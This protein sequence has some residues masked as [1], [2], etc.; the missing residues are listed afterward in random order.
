MRP[1]RTVI[2]MRHGM[3]QPF[4]D[5]R[6]QHGQLTYRGR[7]LC[8]DMGKWIGSDL[9]EK[10]LVREEQASLKT[11]ADSAA[12]CIMSAEAFAEGFLGR[13]GPAEKHEG[14]PAGLFIPG[15]TG[16]SE[17]FRQEAEQQV[18]CHA[19]LSSLDELPYT[20]APELS[21]L[22]RLTG[23]MFSEGTAELVLEEGKGPVLT[24][25]LQTAAA[26]ADTILCH[27]LVRQPF[28]EHLSENDRNALA[29]IIDRYREILF[30]TEIIAKH[31][32]APF[33]QQLQN[34]LCSDAQENLL[35]SVHDTTIKAVLTVLGLS[36]AA[37][38]GNTAGEIP[39]GSC[40]CFEQF[41]DELN[42]PRTQIRRIC[43]TNDQIWE[44]APL[45]RMHPPLS[46]VLL[47]DLPGLPERLSG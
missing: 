26:A 45:N 6:F 9:Q 29:C 38:P 12:R 8:R 20:L 43:P 27:D 1:G 33:L 18:L 31:A 19:G 17:G 46:S 44:G 7:R 41:E 4:S 24:G 13:H 5:T 14:W 39:F 10:G 28:R 3:R 22:E 34:E 25:P 23:R 16:V 37:F 32:L 11:A 30:G 35:L 15:L 40:L 2:L 21:V 42:L 36:D 47:T